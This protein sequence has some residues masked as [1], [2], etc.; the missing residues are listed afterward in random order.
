MSL[1]MG[2]S[3]LDLYPLVFDYGFNKKDRVSYSIQY[4]TEYEVL[5]GKATGSI[6]NSYYRKYD[7]Y[8][9]IIE[10]SKNNID[11]IF[12]FY[13]EKGNWIKKTY[14]HGRSKV[15]RNI[16]YYNDSLISTCETKSMST[17]LLEKIEYN[18]DNLPIKKVT[19]NEVF[20]WKWNAN[21]KLIEWKYIKDSVLVEKRLFHYKQEQL[22]SRITE[23]YLNNEFYDK[24]SISFIYKEKL[25][26][27]EVVF[28]EMKNDK[29]IY[30]N[31]YLYNDN[32][33]VGMQ[34]NKTGFQFTYNLRGDLTQTLI[35]IKGNLIKKIT[36]DYVYLF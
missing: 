3:N 10:Y 8:G 2:Q 25:L 29:I 12:Y 34:V 14:N 9:N 31:I 27:Q 32:V 5:N 33:M 4:S 13:D 1:G 18:K 20:L 16:S 30:S 28:E 26:S 15:I 19:N 17:L 11:T 24:D 21:K 23:Y 7:L 6:L 22:T 35:F 36:Y